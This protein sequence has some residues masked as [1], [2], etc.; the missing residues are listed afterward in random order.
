M[1]CLKRMAETISSTWKPSISLGGG[2]GLLAPETAPIWRSLA[3]C[4]HGNVRMIC[5]N[6]SNNGKSNAVSQNSK[7]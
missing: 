2:I 7:S 4:I 5:A 6:V 3:T 1:S